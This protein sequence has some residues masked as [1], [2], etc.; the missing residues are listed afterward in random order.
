MARATTIIPGHA[1]AGCLGGM[2]ISR[3]YEME[4]QRPE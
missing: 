3:R 4:D 2:W 1:Q